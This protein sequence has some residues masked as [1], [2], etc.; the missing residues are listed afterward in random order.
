MVM[1]CLIKWSPGNTRYHVARDCE[2]VCVCPLVS[3]PLLMKTSVFNPGNSTM[4]AV[5]NPNHIPIP[6]NIIQSIVNIY[7]IN[8]LI[9][10]TKIHHINL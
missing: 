9:I 1:N 3:L 10:R 8:N 4:I 7:S 2:C 6:L 5:Y